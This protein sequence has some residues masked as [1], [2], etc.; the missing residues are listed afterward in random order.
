MLD[1][2]TPPT[3][4][5]VEQISLPETEQIS[6]ASGLPIH[7]YNAGQ[8][9]VVRLEFITRRGSAHQELPGE[10]FFTARMLTEGTSQYSASQIAD[11]VDSL[12]AHLEASASL[13]FTTITLFAL[14]K[15]LP[16]LLPIVYSLLHEATFP[17]EELETL[18]SIKRQRLKIEEAKNSVV[19]TR[20][21]RSSLYPNHAYGKFLNPEHLDDLNQQKLK[22]YYKQNF[23]G[24]VEIFAA[25]Q[26][27]G[28][29]IELLREYFDDYNYKPSSYTFEEIRV[30]SE[31]GV[32]KVNKE[33]SLQSSLRIGKP[34]F[35]SRHKDYHQFTVLNTLLGGYF[36]SRLMKVIRE[37]KGYTYG[38]YSSLNSLKNAG[39]FAIA[40]DVVGEH[41]QASIDEVFRQIKLIQ[42]TPPSVEELETVQNYM[43]GSFL[44]SLNTPFAI[45]DKY[46]NIYFNQLPADFFT[47][48]VQQI[49]STTPEKV[50]ELAQTYLQDED[51]LT[52]AVG[53]V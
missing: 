8:Q 2:R 12:G 41:T 49:Y 48:H 11:K 5:K 27:S 22:E 26:I 15:H 33:N 35:T 1:R 50:Q 46:K 43:V 37:S 32:K 53:A 21:F 10:A 42:Q 34:L 24:Q 20:T 52:V 28:T 6:L 14:E 23:E 38:I 29:T 31:K 3:Y 7:L 16:A 17:E 4:R 18:K 44:G 25:G 13:D 30:N 39:Y 51:M 9:P 47:Q 19:A 36:G 40:A 45:A